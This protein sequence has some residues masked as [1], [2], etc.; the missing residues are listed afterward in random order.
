MRQSSLARFGIASAGKDDGSKKGSGQ[1][2]LDKFKYA[3]SASKTSA[4]QDDGNK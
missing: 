3:G 2:T 1:S 4:K